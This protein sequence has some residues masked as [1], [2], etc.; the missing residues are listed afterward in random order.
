MTV[1]DKYFDAGKIY[2]KNLLLWGGGEYGNS[3]AC[4]LHLNNCPQHV[5][6]CDRNWNAPEKL[7]ERVSFENRYREVYLQP[8][9]AEYVGTDRLKDIVSGNAENFSVI[10]AVGKDETAEEIKKKC[11]SLGIDERNLYRFIKETTEELN[12]KI[13]I[14]RRFGKD[15]KKKI[16]DD[17]TSL[18]EI[19]KK[20]EKKVPF[21][22]SRWGTNENIA[23]MQYISG[24]L[25][26]NSLFRMQSLAGIFP[27]DNTAFL[28]KYFQIMEQ[29]AR[30]IDFF[31]CG[32][33]IPYCDDLQE[34]LSP[35]AGLVHNGILIPIHNRDSWMLALTGK[36]VLVIHPFASLIE[37]QYKNR[38]SIWND[39]CTLPD[40]D[41]KVYAAV[42][43]L[44]GSDVYAT[45]L[46]ALHK[47][48]NDIGRIDFDCALIACGGYGM[49][50]GAFIKSEL[51]K[52]AVHVGGQLQLLFGI[53]G[54]RWDDGFGKDHYNE[55]WVR[56][57]DDL[58]P[59]NFQSVEGGCYW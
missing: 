28:K 26:K 15:E 2:T 57:S 51:K 31:I 4:Y 54:K 27:S 43:S 17:A 9:D 25:N 47:M 39:D 20:I 46:D 50:L 42:Q 12:Q 41:L 55:Y 53:K 44:G 23:Q 36:K 8:L 6:I 3:A 40:W 56:P 52:Q 33:W 38:R 48:E 58:K 18:A 11:I 22:I 35:D 1:I 49:P 32:A 30:K 29:S 24:A 14:K 16:L 21:L 13:N 19:R 34:R 5:L 37:T 7:A 10:I 45:W 59:K